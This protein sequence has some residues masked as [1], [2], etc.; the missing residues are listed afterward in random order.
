MLEAALRSFLM[1]LLLLVAM[2][3][4]ISWSRGLSGSRAIGLVRD[5]PHARKERH[6]LRTLGSTFMLSFGGVRALRL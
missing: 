2:Q 5:Q 6:T 3:F 4:D 1:C